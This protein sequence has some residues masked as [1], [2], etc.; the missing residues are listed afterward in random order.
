M[1]PPLCGPGKE[2]TMGKKRTDNERAV[3]NEAVRLRKL[4]DEELVALLRTQEAKTDKHG[5]GKVRELLNDL[6]NGCCK[7]IKGATAF[8]I[9]QYAAEKGLI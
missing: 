6:S 4:S 1:G 7:G 2:K 5:S 3:H 8:K 9:E